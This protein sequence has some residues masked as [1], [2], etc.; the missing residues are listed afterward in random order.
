MCTS[1]HSKV[2]W[3]SPRAQRRSRQASLEQ[4]VGP[5]AGEGTILADADDATAGDGRAS[6]RAAV[7]WE[8]GTAALDTWAQN[9]LAQKA[10]VSDKDDGSW[11]IAKEAAD[12]LMFPGVPPKGRARTL[13]RDVL[14]HVRRS[15]RADDRR[16]TGNNNNDGGAVAGGSGCLTEAWVSGQ[17]FAWVDLQAGQFEWGP[18]YGG[19]G[20]KSASSYGGSGF[21]HRP[22]PPKSTAGTGTGHGGWKLDSRE[23]AHELERVTR[24]L[25]SRK[26]IL[27]TVVNYMGC[28]DD[29][30]DGVQGME[31]GEGTSRDSSFR[32]GRRRLGV[33]AMACK[34][35]LP[36]LRFLT[37]FLERES[38]AIALDEAEAVTADAAASG[39]VDFSAREADLA[40][41]SVY[42]Y[43]EA[44]NT[45]RA[46]RMRLLK[47]VLH[48][49]AP[50]TED[51]SA[52][53]DASALDNETQALLAH[54][55]AL[56][57]SIARAVVTPVSTLPLP[58]PP[59]LKAQSAS[60]A[61]VG[62]HGTDTPT[63][64]ADVRTLVAGDN[65]AVNNDSIW[66]VAQTAGIRTSNSRSPVR[67]LP[68]G[69]DLAGMQTAGSFPS[70]SRAG[71]AHPLLP[72]PPPSALEFFVPD[73]IAF[74]MYIVQAQDVYAPLGAPSLELEKGEDEG[75]DR[76]AGPAGGA[77]GFDL[78]SFQEGALSLR[79]PSQRASF[80]VH[81]VAAEDDP[82]MAAALAGATRE[83]NVNV[84]TALG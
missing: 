14:E 30:N 11:S 10:P 78:L 5:L 26:D 83:A 36:Q 84:A 32:R 18:A 57:A 29:G 17:R 80:T 28:K 13:L 66:G 1:V 58:S 19:A 6:K 50:A 3:D 40:A 7:R 56:I 72:Q 73:N 25:T 69:P 38:H 37:Q 60:A 59:W 34:E 4:G 77:T 12:L 48:T 16:S 46:R 2:G 67:R 8:P 47:G 75:V 49:L 27:E 76:E 33:A 71:N 68:T 82:G 55:A 15:R 81:Q 22:R 79:L 21:P 52:L 54:L 35:V 39:A 24:K 53:D 74:T 45:L 44:L 41:D 70:L 20:Y 64:C 23:Y 51:D 31:E 65:A 43:E 62:G 61:L 9:R 63:G 42:S